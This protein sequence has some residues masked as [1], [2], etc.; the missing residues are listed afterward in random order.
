MGAFNSAVI[1]K[2]GQELLAKVVAGKTKVL[3]LRGK[4]SGKSINYPFIQTEYVNGLFY[5]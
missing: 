3:E 4:K 1:T 5:R 2:G